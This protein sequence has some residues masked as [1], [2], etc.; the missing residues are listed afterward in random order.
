MQTLANA[1]ETLQGAAPVAP[2]PL[3][4][5]FLSTLHV[6]LLLFILCM[7]ASA[8]LTVFPIGTPPAGL[9][10]AVAKCIQP[11]APKAEPVGAAAALAMTMLAHQQFS[12]CCRWSYD[13]QNVL[14]PC[15][16]LCLFFRAAGTTIFV[17][18][19]G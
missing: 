14:C 8:A 12:F 13:L 3:S 1:L 5:L 9:Q 19:H 16:C 11:V 17:I 18:D 4:S 6:H 15:L 10:P 7:S 2:C